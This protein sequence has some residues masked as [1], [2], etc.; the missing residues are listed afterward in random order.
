MRLRREKYV[1]TKNFLKFSGLAKML[2]N[3]LNLHLQVRAP[4][5][6]GSAM[7]RPGLT[8]TP[9]WSKQH[10]NGST[11]LIHGV[12]DHAY[13]LFRAFLS[14]RRPPAIS[15]FQYFFYCLTLLSYRYRIHTGKHYYRPDNINNPPPSEL[16]IFLRFGNFWRIIIMMKKDLL[17]TGK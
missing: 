14:A 8:Y 15:W 6:S 16:T 2:K 7:H 9:F 5:G 13:G 17:K 3:C 4:P 1:P 10:S 11:M 12:L